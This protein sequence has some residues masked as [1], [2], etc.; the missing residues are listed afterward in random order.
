MWTL[1]KA[2][3]GSIS[4]ASV[5]SG[6]AGTWTLRKVDGGSIT[7]RDVAV[8]TGIWVLQKVSGGSL[9][10]FAGDLPLTMPS[11]VIRKVSGG[12]ADYLSVAVGPTGPASLPEVV[13]INF[14]FGDAPANVWQ[15]QAGCLLLS[16]RLIIRTAFSNG[17]SNIASGRS[18]GSTEILAPGDT[19]LSLVATFDVPVDLALATNDPVWLTITAAG[20][21]TGSGVLT[22]YLSYGSP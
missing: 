2:D 7:S 11:W 20:S 5:P 10:S 14:S 17:M 18:Q 16:V 6:S 12:I 19:I 13:H 1:A 8:S 22:L 21:T 3:G 15:P 9:V 4:S